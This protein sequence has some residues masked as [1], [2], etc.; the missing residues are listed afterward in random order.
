M[1]LI[2][3][4]HY[5]TTPRYNFPPHPEDLQLPPKL[6]ELSLTSLQNLRG[7]FFQPHDVE[8]TEPMLNQQEE[9]KT[10]F[11]RKAFSIQL[12]PLRPVCDGTP[13]IA[14]DVSSV[15][16]GET[17][18]GILCALR[19]AVVWSQKRRYIY[20]RFGPFPVHIGEENKKEVIGLLRGHRFPVSTS[21]DLI[22]IQ[23]KLCNLVEKW[24]QLNVCSSS[25]SSII[26]WDGSLTAG[27]NGSPP[28]VISQLLEISRQRANTVLAFS[29][30][31]KMRFLGHKITEVSLRYPP[32]WIFEVGEMPFSPSL[33]LL[34]NVY[35]ARFRINGY[36]FRLDID[37]MI[38]V[39]QKIDAVQRLIGNELVFQSYPE[40]LRLAHIY[41]TFTANEIIGIQH[42]LAQEFNL[43]LLAPRDLRK[44]LFGP[45]GTGLRD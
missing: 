38:S 19:A 36:S 18:N 3:Q 15:K 31:S 20:H 45:Y 5:S 12:V 32:P 13:I 16:I 30:A 24:I 39:D 44:T 2:Q 1:L 33:H 11:R 41:A 9:D 22:D 25:A 42:Y 23:V 28:G 6:I 17:E 26:L 14:I 4:L 34:G 8:S 21:S 35:V 43:K 27:P 29:K 40:S 7:E 10:S 37:K